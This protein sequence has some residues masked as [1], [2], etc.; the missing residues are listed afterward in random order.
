MNEVKEASYL[1]NQTSPNVIVV[2]IG[3]VT[4][5][6]KTCLSTSLKEAFPDAQIINM[7][8]YYYEEDSPHHVMLEE[9]DNEYANWEVTSAIDF[10]LLHK[11]VCTFLDDSQSR[12][13]SVPSALLIIE[14][15]LIYNYRPLLPFFTKKYFLTLDK[16][17]CWERRRA[18]DYDPPEPEGYFDS[19]AW[20]YYLQNKQE[21][22]DQRDIVYMR[23]DDT[24]D[25]IF[26]KV[27]QDLTALME[28]SP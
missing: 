19:V 16:A 4:N 21:I 14:G 26:N 27:L 15:I 7:D 2:G 18:R 1:L 24:R 12:G 9:F 10:Q 25:N 17:V 22:D 28:S 13:T 5:G 23:G 20:P 6:G 3:G 8:G 11:D